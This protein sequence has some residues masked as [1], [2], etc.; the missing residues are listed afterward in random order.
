MKKHFNFSVVIGRFQVPHQGHIKLIQKAYEIADKV[1]ILVG[2]VGQPETPKNPFSYEDRIKML[3]LIIPSD[4]N[5]DIFPVRDQ[6]YNLDSWIVDVVNKVKSNFPREWSDK[7]PKVALVGHKKDSSSFYL[8]MFPQW[9]FID[10]DNHCGVSS[11]HLRE[12]LFEGKHHEDIDH[13]PQPI[14][15][16]IDR[17]INSHNYLYLKREYKAIK[18]YKESWKY[19]PYPPIFVTVDAVVVQS[20]HILL[21]KR[22]DTPGKGLW[23]LPGGFV[24]QEESIREAVIRELVEETKIKLQDIILDKAITDIKVYDHPDRSQRGRTITHAFKFALRPGELPRIKGSS[25][26]EKAQW[27]PLN[28][29]FMMGDVIYEDH[30]DIIL[31]MVR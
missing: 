17:W 25:D 4:I 31:D 21:V 18:E 13:L 27:F 29:V 8:D 30:L 9:K 12:A 19:A 20:G 2:S 5:Y 7:P 16:F 22:K 23:A 10:F 11:T 14:H 26:A 3:E 24:N 1:I 6:R 28:E 15:K